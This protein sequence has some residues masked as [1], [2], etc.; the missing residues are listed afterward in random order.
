MSEYIC[1]ILFL[2]SYILINYFSQETNFNLFL[3]NT[4]GVKISKDAK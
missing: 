4:T 1:S 2:Y 3:C